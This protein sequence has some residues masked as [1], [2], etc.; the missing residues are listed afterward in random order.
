MKYLIK[1][2]QEELTM[3]K[4]TTAIESD[5]ALQF[6]SHRW[7][8]DSRV[9]ERA[10]NIL[11]ICLQIIDFWKTL[12]KSKQPGRGKSYD[13]LVKKPS[14]LLVSVKLNFLKEFADRL[15]SFLVTFQTDVLMVP[16]LVDKLEEIV[17][18]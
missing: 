18:F 11:E 13:T 2:Q 6:C 14:D 9:A 1:N 17:R 16:L 12:S 10:E 3:K 15:Y 8:E 4:I 5:N 7:I